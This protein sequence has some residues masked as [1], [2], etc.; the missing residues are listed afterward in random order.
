[1]HYNIIYYC[2]WRERNTIGSVKTI[3]LPHRCGFI[4]RLK[5]NLIGSVVFLVLSSG[6]KVSRKR[7]RLEYQG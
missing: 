4:S 5:A 1:M 3:K 6:M 7:H 2:S